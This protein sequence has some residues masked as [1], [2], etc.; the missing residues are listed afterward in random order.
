MRFN[1]ICRCGGT[2]TDGV[3]LCNEC[4]PNPNRRR[5]R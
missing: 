5:G 1:P 2:I 4:A 3:F